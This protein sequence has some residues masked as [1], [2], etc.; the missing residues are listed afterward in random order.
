[1]VLV[2]G[3]VLVKDLG[4]SNRMALFYKAIVDG[5]ES[6]GPLFWPS[7]LCLPLIL[8][9]LPQ[10]IDAIINNTHCVCH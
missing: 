8:F 1:M 3:G 9:N 5:P 10:F 6:A 7:M 2:K 4:E